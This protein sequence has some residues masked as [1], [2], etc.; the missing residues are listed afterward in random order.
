[1]TNSKPLFSNA[2]SK[3]ER[4]N[5]HIDELRRRSNPLDRELYEISDP[6]VRQHA[7]VIHRNPTVYRVA[8]RPKV[9]IPETF[10][11][12]I[13]DAFNNI[14]EAFDFSAVA[15]VDAWGTRPPGKL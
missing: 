5:R 4:A 11:G 1:M 10:A 7:T 9:D 6:S 2:R 8:Y 14:R 12:I 3:I 15:I 13:G